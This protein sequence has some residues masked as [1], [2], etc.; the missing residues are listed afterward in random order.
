MR[1]VRPPPQGPRVGG[2]RQG[3]ADGEGD[4]DEVDQHDEVDEDDQDDEERTAVVSA[5]STGG[6]KVPPSQ[7]GDAIVQQARAA[8]SGTPDAVASV[9]RVVRAAI[10]LAALPIGLVPVMVAGRVLGFFS[11]DRAVDVFVGVGLGRFLPL[12]I[13]VIPWGLVSATIAHLAIGG[14]ARLRDSWQVGVDA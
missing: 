4:D 13:I 10:W 6:K 2:G 5:A 8:S 3:P 12:V 7:R 9:P 14:I 11:V 1:G